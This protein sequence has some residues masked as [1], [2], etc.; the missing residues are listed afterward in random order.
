MVLAYCPPL[1]SIYKDTHKTNAL[2]LI[3]LFLFLS[4]SL[5]SVGGEKKQHS[6]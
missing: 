4:P 3:S 5:W 1:T 2:H 6:E